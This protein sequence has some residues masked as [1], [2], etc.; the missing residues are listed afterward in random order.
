MANRYDPVLKNLFLRLGPS[1]LQQLTGGRQIRAALNVE[2]QQLRDV[3]E[4]KVDLLYELDDD[5]LLHLDLQAQN[6]W[7]MPWREL[8]YRTL[9]R[10]LFKRPVHQ[11]VL[12]V[13]EAA[14]TMPD[15]IDEPG[16]TFQYELIDIRSFTAEEL[17][18]TNRPGDAVLAF[19]ASGVADRA[20]LARQIVQRVQPL[21]MPERRDALVSLLALS[22]LRKSATIVMEVL[23]SMSLAIDWRENEFL[24]EIH[25]SALQE[26]ERAGIQ[27]GKREGIQEGKREGIQEGMCATLQ[28]LLSQRFGPLPSWAVDRL[29]SA[30]EGEL[31]EALNKVLTAATLQDVLPA[32]K[33]N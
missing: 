28:Q 7:D 32:A 10:N 2:L 19:L 8:E 27:K 11:A 16:L 18:A 13:G 31:Q 23:K 14:M 30:Q 4:R 26:G 3:K 20:T 6:E 12:Y 21:P 5:S 22:G 17:L 33:T 24:R 1:L 15:R 9:L 25:D 29:H